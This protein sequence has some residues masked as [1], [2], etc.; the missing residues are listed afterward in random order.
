MSDFNPLDYRSDYEDEAKL[1]N[2][3]SQNIRGY[4]PNPIWANLND[5]DVLKGLML[6]GRHINAPWVYRV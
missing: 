3:S 6:W 1:Q 5:P 2:P 4:D